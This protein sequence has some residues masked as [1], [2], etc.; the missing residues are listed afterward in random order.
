MRNYANPQYTI[1][2]DDI[3]LASKPFLRR[4]AIFSNEKIIVE[5]EGHDFS[6]KIPINI[7]SVICQHLPLKS[8]VNL[9][10]TNKILDKSNKIKTGNNW[11]LLELNDNSIWQH[12]CNLDFYEPLS[13]TEI[14]WK[15]RYKTLSKGKAAITET[16]FQDKLYKFRLNPILTFFIMF[17]E[18]FVR[19]IDWLSIILAI[20]VVLLPFFIGWILP[21][22]SEKFLTLFM[23]YTTNWIYLK[24]YLHAIQKIQWC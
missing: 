21:P 8:I 10:Q 2:Y 14:S 1:T 5:S 13:L 9:S 6:E 20:L 18:W 3:I 16:I 7:L 17:I 19:Q 22:I 11:F 12:L 15:N 24:S 4:R 23:K